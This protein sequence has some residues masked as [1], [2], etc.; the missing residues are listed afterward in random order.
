M[1]YY[2]YI[3]REDSNMPMT[4]FICTVCDINNIKEQHIDAHLKSNKHSKRLDMCFKILRINERIIYKYYKKR[5]FKMV[6]Q[7]HK[8]NDHYIKCIETPIV[9]Q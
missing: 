8:D 7:Y 2:I 1:S 3:T 6:T 5:D 9:K 4:K